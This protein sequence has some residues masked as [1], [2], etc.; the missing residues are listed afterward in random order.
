MKKIIYDDEIFFES[1]KELREKSNSYNKLLEQPHMESLILNF[2]NKKILD[3]GCGFGSNSIG[4]IEKGAN[5][6][7][8]IDNSEKMLEVAVNINNDKNI[9][10]LNLDLDELEELKRR[11][12]KFDM[13]YSSLVFHYIKDFKK[14]IENING[15]LKKDG[16]LI[17]S[18][19][20]P[21]T[22]APIEGI[23][24]LR[25]EDNKIYYK[26]SDYGIS[27]ERKVNWFIDNIS[28]YHRTFSEIMEMV[29]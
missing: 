16:F 13:V 5:F 22:L 25:D 28:K 19:E 1:Y 8:G 3:L 21:L 12:L 10:Y 20:H 18:Q 9:E 6:V 2:K 17:F 26:L 15:L 4:F 14:L 7:L 27:G 29:M 24:W 11:N 23:K